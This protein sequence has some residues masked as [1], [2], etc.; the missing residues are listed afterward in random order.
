MQR[1][2]RHTR[3]WSATTSAKRKYC[4]LLS[5]PLIL[6]GRV[7]RKPAKAKPGLKVNRG[8][9]FSCIKVLYVAFI[10]CSLRILVLKNEGQKI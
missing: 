5:A 3:L 7:V 9:N 8:N 2:K 4:I 1:T 10:L 6:L